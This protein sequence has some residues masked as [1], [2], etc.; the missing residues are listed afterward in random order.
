M[1]KV[2]ILAVK[3]DKAGSDVEKTTN[4]YT[5]KENLQHS[6]LLVIMTRFNG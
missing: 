6:D 2:I 4:I 5:L 1:Q 3:K